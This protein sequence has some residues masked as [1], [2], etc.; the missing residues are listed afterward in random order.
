MLKEI[1]DFP[2]YFID[3]NGT[4]WTNIL[5]GPTREGSTELRKVKPRPGK[6]KYLRVYMRH[7]SGKRLD[8]YIHRLVAEAFIPN[9]E[10]K[11]YVDHL[12]FN[13]MN[14]K[15]SNLQWITSKENN[16]R[17]KD[18]FHVLINEKG[19]FVSNY[20]YTRYSLLPNES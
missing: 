13:R 6:N 1:K 8:R 14:N 9:P 18:S 16:Q 19:Q 5:H 2:H 17:T 12:D 7:I 15:I 10:N 11:K 3:E 20:D 4:V